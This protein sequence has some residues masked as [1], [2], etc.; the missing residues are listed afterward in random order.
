MFLISRFYSCQILPS[1][2]WYQCLQ[3]VFWVVEFGGPGQGFQV[4]YDW[5]YPEREKSMWQKRILDD[6]SLISRFSRDDERLS[7]HC[8]TLAVRGAALDKPPSDTNSCSK[9]RRWLCD[10]TALEAALWIRSQRVFVGSRSLITNIKK[11][12][13]KKQGDWESE[14]S[15]GSVALRN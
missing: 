9:R 15:K 12:V 1:A 10:L 8:T 4:F 6:S 5:G 7:E 14:R 11:A 3:L 2:R 13:R